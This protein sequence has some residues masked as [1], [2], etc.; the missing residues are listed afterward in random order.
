MTRFSYELKVP[1]ERIAVLIGKNGEVKRQLEELTRSTIRVDSEE[2]DVFVEGDDALSLYTTR[3]IIQAVSRG[4]NPEVAT[5]L[6]KQDYALEILSIADFA[7]TKNH[8]VRI[9]GRIIGSEGK[10]RRA[11]EAL[12]DAHISVYGKTV[13]IIG[14]TEAA[15]YAKRAIEMLLSGSPHTNVYKM[16]EKRRKEMK[17]KWMLPRDDGKGDEEP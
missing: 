6:L 17:L 11:I 12:T 4:F 7:K 1:R 10:A 14:E 2:G 8:L 15:L 13:A 5:L 16:L 3:E 9:K